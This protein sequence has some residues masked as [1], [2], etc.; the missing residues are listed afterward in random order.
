M[1]DTRDGTTPGDRLPD[2]PDE[3]RP[4]PPLDPPSS[5]PGGIVIR[6]DRREYPVP[7]DLLNDG[8]LTGTAIRRLA[9]PDIA[10]DR[11]LFEVVLGGSDRKIGNDEEVAIRDGL[12]FF[13]APARINPG[14]V[15]LE[16]SAY[17]SIPE[18]KARPVREGPFR[19]KVHVAG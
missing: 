4:R 11:D 14:V 7:R 16:D 3:P 2:R 15:P 10:D 17:G 6:I 9:D 12:R 13:S 1:I 18:R 19:G 8:K 5:V